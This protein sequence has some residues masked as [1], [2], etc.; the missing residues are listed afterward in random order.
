MDE[1]DCKTGTIIIAEPDLSQDPIPE[2]ITLI[3]AYK[4]LMMDP[5]QQKDFLFR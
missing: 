4:Y 3:P 5:M 2:N 1:L